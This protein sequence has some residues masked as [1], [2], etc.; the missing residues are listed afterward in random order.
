MSDRPGTAGTDGQRD[1]CM[2]GGAAR[3]VLHSL[4]WPVHAPAAVWPRACLCWHVRA[5]QQLGTALTP[6]P[7]SLLLLP[8]FFLERPSDVHEVWAREH[9]PQTVLAHL[10]LVQNSSPATSM[11]WNHPTWSI[12]AE[13]G[14]YLLFPLLATPVAL[15]WPGVARRG[16][17][18][19]S[20]TQ[21]RRKA[22]A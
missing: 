6:T 15:R 21:S 22:T 12:G 8:R 1:A 18:A 5:E 7:L 9:F 17:K 11:V 10:F 2:P 3:R 13:A 14:F 20:A 19:P 16:G 4:L